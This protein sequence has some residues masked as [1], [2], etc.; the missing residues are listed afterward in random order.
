MTVVE[1]EKAGRLSR[2]YF[3]IT[4]WTRIHGKNTDTPDVN[5]A[6]ITH[7]EETSSEGPTINA[8]RD[9]EIDM[10][11]L[12]QLRRATRYYQPRGCLTLSRGVKESKG[13]DGHLPGH[14]SY[15]PDPWWGWPLKSDV[16]NDVGSQDDGVNGF[17]GHHADVKEG[18]GL[19][20]TEPTKRGANGIAD[21][22]TDYDNSIGADATN[23]LT[24]STYT[25]PDG[26]DGLPPPR[27]RKYRISMD[28]FEDLVT[29]GARPRY[30]PFYHTSDR[31]GPFLTAS[32]N[33]RA[34]SRLDTSSRSETAQVCS[35]ILLLLIVSLTLS[36]LYSY[37]KGRVVAAGKPCDHAK[38]SKNADSNDREDDHSP[39]EHLSY[40]FFMTFGYILGALVALSTT[41]DGDNAVLIACV[42]LGVSTA[43]WLGMNTV[44]V[45]NVIA[46]DRYAWTVPDPDYINA[47]SKAV[48]KLCGIGYAKIRNAIW[49][50]VWHLAFAIMLVAF[51]VF[52]LADATMTSLL[53]QN[54]TSKHQYRAASKKH[55][56]GNEEDETNAS[57]K[58]T[59]EPSLA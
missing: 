46:Y 16:I 22:S 38:P 8:P 5:S 30:T 59:P 48:E 6:P 58:T 40:G 52:L 57:T 24:P 55:G 11:K 27:I 29:C 50:V 51:T 41:R 1:V 13:L 17:N 44:A 7:S 20:D 10:E 25:T 47:F 28:R 18:K 26:E 42:F 23:L 35:L 4:K 36:S 2:K 15:D 45:L 32:S 53:G 31:T 37:L 49:S 12:A 39:K 34:I 56:K 33:H 21:A 14:G 3:P 43:F 19:Y 54:S 9:S